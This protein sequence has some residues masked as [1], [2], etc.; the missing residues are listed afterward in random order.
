M[1]RQFTKAQKEAVRGYY[2]SRKHS[3]EF[4]TKSDCLDAIADSTRNSHRIEAFYAVAGTFWFKWKDGIT[5]R[6]SEKNWWRMK[7]DT[8]T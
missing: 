8:K 4:K 3:F 5:T 6:H 2:S 7:K 1:L